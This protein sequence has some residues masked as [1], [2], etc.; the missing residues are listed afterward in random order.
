[1][2]TATAVPVERVSLR[3]LR[4]VLLAVALVA[5]IAASFFIGRHSASST[6]SNRPSVATQTSTV[7]ICRFGKLC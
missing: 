4:V 6:S 1:M 7:D 3:G 2:T 5:L